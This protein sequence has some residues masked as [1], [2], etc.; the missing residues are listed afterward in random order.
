MTAAVPG[1]TTVTVHYLPHLVQ[2]D[3]PVAPWTALAG[4]LSALASGLDDEQPPASRLVEIAVCYAP[5]FA[6][7]LADVARHTGLAP[8]EVVARHTAPTYLVHMIGFLPG[9]AYLGGMDP[10]LATPR[11]A[12]PR[13]AVPAGSV[14]IGGSQT[15]VYPIASPGGWHLIGRSATPLLDPGA[16]SPSL[17][18]AGDR[19]RFHAVSEAEFHAAAGR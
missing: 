19:V 2:R 12:T 15:G 4:R 11:R 17:L 8:D 18:R 9:F 7:D 1:F 16:A 10:R 3:A 6:P 5:G 14:G 13:T